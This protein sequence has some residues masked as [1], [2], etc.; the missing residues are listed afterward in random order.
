MKGSVFIVVDR[1][2]YVATTVRNLSELDSSTLQKFEQ[3]V[4]R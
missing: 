4:A 3:V 2:Y 1:R